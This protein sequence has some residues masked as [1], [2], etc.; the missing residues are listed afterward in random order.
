MKPFGRRSGYVRALSACAFLN[1]VF[2]TSV[3]AQ[4]INGITPLTF[5]RITAVSTGSVVIDSVANTRTASLGVTILT[6]VTVQRGMVVITGTPNAQVHIL[7]PAQITISAPGGAIL[8]PEIGGGT[9]QTIGADGT[10]TV[11][12]GGQLELADPVNEGEYT[13]TIPMSVDYLP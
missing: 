2:G 3:Y 8:R 4:V 9:V 13:T 7:V 11:F 12:I 1:G 6:D 10:L 5:G